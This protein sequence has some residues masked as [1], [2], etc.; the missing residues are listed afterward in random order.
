MREAAKSNERV[1]GSKLRH[2]MQI[3]VV[4]L[5]NTKGFADFCQFPSFRQNIIQGLG[6]PIKTKFYRDLIR[7]SENRLKFEF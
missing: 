6:H 4:Y 7:S 3:V 1:A 2:S 5:W